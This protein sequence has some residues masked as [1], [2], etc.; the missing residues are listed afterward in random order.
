MAIMLVAISC[1]EQH[2]LKLDSQEPK[3]L[4]EC[5]P[6]MNDTTVV[7][8]KA[9][10]PVTQKD[11]IPPSIAGAVV[12]MKVDGVL[13]DVRYAASNLGT[14]PAG[15]FFSVGKIACGS[16]IEISASAPGIDPVLSSTTMPSPVGDVKFDL[17]R[18]ASSDCIV[19]SLALPDDI[20]YLGLSIIQETTFIRSGRTIMQHY[21]ERGNLVNTEYGDLETETGVDEYVIVPSPLY[22]ND[23]EWADIM[24]FEFDGRSILSPSGAEYVSLAGPS[25]LTS[26]HRFEFKLYLDRDGE[27]STY[28]DDGTLILYYSRACRLRFVIYNLSP[29][30]FRFARARYED[31]N[32]VLGFV[33]LAPASFTYTNV[34]GGFGAVGA[35]TVWESGW[36]PNP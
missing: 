2:D 20:S 34:R 33:G 17:K 22:E 23:L 16:R 6:G 4:V 13:R 31:Y 19:A 32:N 24:D 36:Y 30:M 28:S 26:D 10:T 8:L 7:L 9:A 15:S 3:L 1:E 12:E 29:E 21:D 25:D 11:S 18:D 14:V 35:Y 5:F 27:H